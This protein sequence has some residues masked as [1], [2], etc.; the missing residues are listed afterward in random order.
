M[1]LPQNQD[2]EWMRLAIEQAKKAED[3][4]EVPVGAI[5]VLDNQVL[6]QSGNRPIQQNDPTAHAEIT[7]IRQ[8][9][10]RLRNYRINHT[11]LYVTLEP[12][13]MCA[14]AIVQARIARVVFG[15]YDPKAGAC[16]SVFDIFNAPHIN[17]RPVQQGGVLAQECGQLLTTFFQQKRQS[18]GVI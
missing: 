15:A 9:A 11:T 7:V 8:A 14:G 5:L 6:A 1:G 17:H 16:G 3:A 4:G 10:E 12:C 18:K 2:I 13:C